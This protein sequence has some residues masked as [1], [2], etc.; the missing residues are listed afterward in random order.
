MHIFILLLFLIGPVA[1]ASENKYLCKRDEAIIFGCSLKT[2]MV[3]LCSSKSVSPTLG[4]VQYRYGTL[5]KLEMVYPNRLLPPKGYFFLGQSG[6]SGGGENRIRFNNGK[7]NYLIFDILSKV[8]DPPEPNRWRSTS[9]IIVGR[10]NKTLS[11]QICTNHSDSSF[12]ST[13]GN[14]YIY[15]SETKIENHLESPRWNPP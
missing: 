5:D 11:L 6:W 8:S 10:D 1:E 13:G 14:F 2:K 9:G 15:E 4:Y 12:K 7:Y 3:S